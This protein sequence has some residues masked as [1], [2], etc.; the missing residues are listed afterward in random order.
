L[1]QELVP[2]VKW[3]ERPSTTVSIDFGNAVPQVWSFLSNDFLDFVKVVLA[4]M[5][6]WLGLVELQFCS[7]VLF[8]LRRLVLN[9]YVVNRV[10]SLFT[11]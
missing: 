7:P 3:M 1:S 6:V 5:T 11:V 8:L 10:Q 9:L 4:E 2:D